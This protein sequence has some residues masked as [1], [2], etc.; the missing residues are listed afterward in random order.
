MVDFRLLNPFATTRFTLHTSLSATECAARLGGQ[1]LGW[2]QLKGLFGPGAAP[3]TGSV[4]ERGFRVRRRTS[5]P[6][7]SYQPLARGKWQERDD[8]TDVSVQMFEDP[9]V[10]WLSLMWLAVAMIVAAM[11]VST[12]AAGELSSDLTPVSVPAMLLLPSLGLTAQMYA[13][14]MARH[15]PERVRAFL[16]DLLEATDEAQHEKPPSAG[17][18]AGAAA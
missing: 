11:F 14:W 16:V 5:F 2:F 12:A 9:A 10:A 18:A 1:T 3:M 17:V 7:N 13:R 6:R 4:D 15:E 8:G